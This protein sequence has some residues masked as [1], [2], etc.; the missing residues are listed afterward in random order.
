MDTSFI[1]TASAHSGDREQWVA[2]VVLAGIVGYGLWR[3]LPRLWSRPATPDPWSPED[4]ARIE[5]DEAEPLCPA[6]LDPQPMHV[7]FCSKCGTPI[8]AYVGYLPFERILAEGHLLRI[9]T[10]ETMRPSWIH[11]VGLGFW[12]LGI[13]GVLAPLYWILL[14]RNVA[15]LRRSSRRSAVPP[16]IESP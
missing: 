1:L 16:E 3:G 15:R 13:F 12:A 2:Y 10:N 5:S 14:A 7:H 8:G 11:A 9:G 4:A 6:C